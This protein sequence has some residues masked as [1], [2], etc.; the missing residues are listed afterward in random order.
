MIF[1]EFFGETHKNVYYY[2]NQTMSLNFF[3]PDVGN[4]VLKCDIY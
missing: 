2:S 3:K 1:L 4:I